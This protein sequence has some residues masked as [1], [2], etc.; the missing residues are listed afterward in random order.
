MMGLLVGGAVTWV[1]LFLFYLAVL[2][3]MPDD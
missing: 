1:A 2:A 3:V